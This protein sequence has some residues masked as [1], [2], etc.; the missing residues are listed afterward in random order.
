[1]NWFRQNRFLS[2]FLI[3]LGIA[4]I[5]S[6]V[7]L[8]QAKSRRDEAQA[9][10]SESATELFRLQRLSPFPNEANLQK[11]KAQAQEYAADLS[12]VKEALKTRMLPT[13]AIAPNEFQTRLNQ[14][15]TIFSEKARTNK[16]KLPE[17]FFL[18][19]EEFAAAL[20][21]TAAA[22]LLA[23]ELAQVELMLNIIIEA[24]VDAITSLRRVPLAERSAP[25]VTP[26]PV[27]GRPTP[28][29]VAKAPPLIE[30]NVIDLS[31]A[32]TPSALRRV[33]NQLATAE[34]QFY[35]VRTL[36]VLNEEE[37]GPPREGAS[38]PP[39]TATPGANTA[40]NFIVGNEHIQADARIEMLRFTY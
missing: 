26:A 24:R 16:V 4:T 37:K 38:A 11:M 17:N 3:V 19:F 25:V 14:L 32:G 27:A 31:F 9:R 28:T 36:H 7:F 6:A 30:R 12:K 33:L 1:M 35:I 29:A 15:R 34:Q 2:Q 22:P 5:A 13:P 10:F 23:Q 18:G 21:D 20:P 39:A 40:L 8:W